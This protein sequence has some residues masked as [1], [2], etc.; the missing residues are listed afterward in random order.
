MSADQLQKE[1]RKRPHS[2]P[3]P[4]AYPRTR[5]LLLDN[6]LT[7]AFWHARRLPPAQHC[8]IS[9]GFPKRCSELPCARVPSFRWR[10][11]RQR[12]GGAALREQVLRGASHD[13]LRRATDSSC[14]RPATR[15][16]HT[17][18]VYLLDMS[19]AAP[20]SSWAKAWDEQTTT[21]PSVSTST[22][23]QVVLS[24]GKPAGCGGQRR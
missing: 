14:R 17:A 24:S 12:R 8:Q 3:L 5:K 4:T 10:V 16:R 20:S 1:I 19:I 15:A 21:R 13:A 11:S 6:S 18:F 9:L 2:S 7:F 22:N 23:P